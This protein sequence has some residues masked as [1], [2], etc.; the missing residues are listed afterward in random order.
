LIVKKIHR[1]QRRPIPDWISRLAGPVAS[2]I[3]LKPTMLVPPLANGAIVPDANGDGSRVDT[4]RHQYADDGG[5][6]DTNSQAWYIE[7]TWEINDQF[8]VQIGIRN[9]K[10]E[11][12]NADGEAFIEIDDQWAPRFALQWSPGGSNEQLSRPTLFSD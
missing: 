1:I 4:V 11:N 7:D 10:F 12:K 2:T 3:G 8:T 5:F 6:Y 9:E